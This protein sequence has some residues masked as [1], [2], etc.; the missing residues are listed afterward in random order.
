MSY[1][2]SAKGAISYASLGHRPRIRLRVCDQA[3]KARFNPVDVFA[4]K[5]EL[6]WDVNRAFT[7]KAFGVAQADSECRA[8][9]AKPYGINRA[10]YNVTRRVLSLIFS[11]LSSPH[12]AK[13]VLLIPLP[14]RIC[15]QLEQVSMAIPF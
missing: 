1:L 14:R 7:P 6:I 2:F 15:L 9:G 4:N 10:G 3:L 11:R 12:S 5:N 13:K 8:F